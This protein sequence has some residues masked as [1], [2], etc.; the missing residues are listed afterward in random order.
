MLSRSISMPSGRWLVAVLTGVVLA[1]A[2]PAAASAQALPV[3]L[4]C[5]KFSPAPLCV[6]GEQTS[7]ARCHDFSVAKLRTP[8]QRARL[9]VSAVCAV[10]GGERLELRR[11]EP[12][13][14]NPA[15]LLLE[16]IVFRS[17]F[18]SGP[19]TREVRVT[20]IEVDF[21]YKSVTILPDGPTLP[22]EEVS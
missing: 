16:L 17:P 12:Q 13:G 10:R 6:P 3:P 18:P 19:P 5:D 4:P 7:T 9:V 11:V 14:I 21:G 1:V 15:N 2:V 20:H 8:G 22:I